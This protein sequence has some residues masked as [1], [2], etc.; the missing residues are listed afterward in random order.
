MRQGAIRPATE[1]QLRE[2]IL[3]VFLLTSDEQMYAGV[4]D[5]L[6]AHFESTLGYFGFID[7]RGDLV[8]PSMTREV[9][10]RCQVPGK[11]IVFPKESWSGIWGRILKER[12]TLF[13]NSPHQVPDGHLPIVRS[14]GTPILYRER[15][16]G[17][18]HLANR[19]RDYT[20]H[21]A[22][23][24]QTIGDLIAPVLAARLQR[25]REERQRCQAET[26]LQRYQAQLETL[27]TER[28]EELARTNQQLQQTLSALAENA[29]RLRAIA[30]A[31]PD[32]VLVL[33]ED[34]HYIEILNER[35]QALLHVDILKK[36]QGRVQGLTLHEVLPAEVADTFLALIRQTLTAGAPRLIEYPLETTGGWRWFE[37]H[38]TPCVCPH[39]GRAAVVWLARDITS[40]K[41][42]QQEMQQA[43]SEAEAANQAKSIFLANMSH[44]IRTPLNGVM[45]MAELLL[46]TEL[47]Q[48][49]RHLAETLCR[50]GRSLLTIVDDVL[51]FA[52]IEA[53]KLQ[54]QPTEFDP[55]QLLQD[56]TELLMERADSKGLRLITDL[57]DWLPARVRGDAGRLRQVLV[58]LLGNALKF[59]DQG[60]V[61][62]SLSVIDRQADQVM[63][64]F[65]VA[66]TGIGISSSAQADIF[67]PFTQADVTLTRRHGGTGLG[68]AICRQLVRLMGG[69]IGVKTTPCVGSR[70]WFTVALQIIS[71]SAPSPVPVMDAKA[72]ALLTAAVLV[73]EDNSINQVVAKAMLEHIGCRV[74]VVDNGQ[75]A[76][77]VLERERYDLLLLDCQMPVMDGFAMIAELRHREAADGR[78]RLPVIALTANVTK[79]FREECLAAGMDD[80]L[81]KPF[82]RQ[83]LTEQLAKW[84]VATPSGDPSSA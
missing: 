56:T 38:L 27:V 39:D 33:D 20:E 17:Q 72:P 35:Q 10:E 78:A 25:D 7:E 61:T 5:L 48:R 45:G 4:L 47:T 34:G 37:G 41:Q 15:L 16:I 83:Q 75:D 66:D 62:I 1:S 24:L 3:Q 52:K 80:Y 59:T 73:A 8:C 46:D 51:D 81:G 57:P 68:L 43:K 28:T 71:S 9:F 60:N 82:N 26:E 19:A 22:Q 13:K 58:N 64:R 29:A 74:T 50:S 84:L 23:T 63:L 6:L 79:G 40:R 44:E 21:D 69:E 32:L 49:Q 14:L 55:R 53:G 2:A 65:T 76:L 42:A 18:I 54:L 36:F 30:N 67:D 77:R 70:F 12:L 31:L 11:Q